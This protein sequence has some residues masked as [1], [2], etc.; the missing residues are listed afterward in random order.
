MQDSQGPKCVCYINISD[1][2]TCRGI[3]KSRLAVCDANTAS[4]LV[5]SSPLPVLMFL[6]PAAWHC[7]ALAL[8]SALRIVLDGC[9]GP[10]ED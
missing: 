9:V 7:V 5:S 4:W 10:G 2:A 8:H 3:M 6:Y 1:D